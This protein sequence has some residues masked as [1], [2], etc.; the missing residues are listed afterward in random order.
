M[1]A[2]LPFFVSYAHADAADVERF[3]KVMRPLLKASAEFA[4][5]EWIDK[6]LLPGKPWFDQIAEA[7]D[8]AQ[9]GLLLVSPEFLASDFIQE[10][11]V[12]PLMGKAVLVPV[13]LHELHLDG[14]LEM[15]GL[16]LRQIFHDSKGR[17]FDACRSA[18]DRRTFAK[19]LFGKIVLLLRQ[20][21]VAA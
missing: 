21:A 6:Q 7:R 9:F 3:R 19:E 4:F 12:P 20:Q 17:S 10:H 18:R 11:E 15:N 5:A 16:H 2:P 1:K 13:A 14:S 8:A